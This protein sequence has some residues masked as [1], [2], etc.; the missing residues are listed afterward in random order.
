M[1]NF[2]KTRRDLHLPRKIFHLVVISMITLL[3]INCSRRQCWN[4]YFFVG[5]PLFILD[6]LRAYSHRWN[7]FALKVIGPVI[8]KHEIQKLSGSSWAFLGIGLTY[9]L[10]PP[11]IAQLST[12][13]L[14]IGDPIASF[15]GVLYGRTKIIGQKSF[16]G[17]L[18]AF[19][20]CT[21]GAAFFF[22]I[23]SP[24]NLTTPYWILL[25]LLC[26]FTGALSELIP[27]GKLD[28]NLTQP[29]LNGVLLTLIIGGF[30]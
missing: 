8:R 3:M 18:A 10:F 27:F 29:L 23:L 7:K 17:S 5:L 20:F 6:F 30:Q 19:V 24:Y 16:A 15:F 12:L 2:F 25:T 11:I 22:F 13:F 4:L 9:F 1:S 21:M 28:D 26:G 14:A